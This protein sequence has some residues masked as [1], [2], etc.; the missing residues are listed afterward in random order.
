MKR[1]LAIALLVAC[2]S[3]PM[4]L[5]F[6]LTDGDAQSCVSDTGVE[7]TDCMAVTMLCP[8]VVSIR[9]VPPSDPTV[10]YISVCKPLTGKQLCS[11]AGVDLPEPTVPV[12]EQVLEVQMAVFPR[13]AITETDPLTGELICP[14][15]E[16]G[17]NGLPVDNLPPCTE[18]DPRKCPVVPAVGGRTYYYPGDEKTVIDLGCTYLEQVQSRTCSGEN[19][20]RVSASVTDFDTGFSVS[21]NTAQRLVVSVGE[22]QP[23][24]DIY[25]LNPNVTKQLQLLTNLTPPVWGA[26]LNV[27][28]TD[29]KAAK[30]LDVRDIA[31]QSTAALTCSPVDAPLGERLDLQG[32]TLS[33]NTLNQILAALGKTTFPIEGLVVG[34]VLDTTNSP[35]AGVRVV[36][37]TGNVVFLSAD[38]TSLVPIQTSTSGIFISQD[39]TFGTQFQV[40]GAGVEAT[41]GFGGLVEDRVTIVVIRLKP[42]STG[43]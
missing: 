19:L 24:G 4:S 40:T 20:V 3:P 15:V 14:I 41:V 13:S 26:T 2:N 32:V 17:A 7:T 37:T 8:A 1:A 36:P 29:F 5:R 38:R 23:V 39:A 28:P 33:R 27:A 43:G 25:A 22:P 6:R 42:P 12:P 11:I 21:G 10:P 18:D 35:V 31:A 30:C 34:I 16:F 9:I